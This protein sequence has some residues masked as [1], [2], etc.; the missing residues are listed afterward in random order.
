MCLNIVTSNN[1]I[2]KPF[3]LLQSE[4][5]IPSKI[6]TTARKSFYWINQNSFVNKKYSNDIGIKLFRNKLER[7]GSKFKFNKT[8]FIWLN[9]KFKSRPHERKLTERLVFEFDVK[10]VLWKIK[11]GRKLVTR[12]FWTNL[13]TKLGEVWRDDGQCWCQCMRSIGVSANVNS[14]EVFA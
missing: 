8:T 6:T 9:S 14:R 12:C 7:N 2:K 5:L 11:H 13:W 10:S 1:S 4:F 3:V